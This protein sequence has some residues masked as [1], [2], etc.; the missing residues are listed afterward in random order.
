MDNVYLHQIKSL[1]AEQTGLRIL[2]DNMASFQRL[3]QNRMKVFKLASE[4]DYYQLLLRFNRIE[5][6]CEA[7][8]LSLGLTTGETYFFRDHGQIELLSQ[9]I[10]PELIERN[11][12]ERR[13]RIWSAGCSSGEEPYSLAML[14]D[15][16]DED[17]SNWQVLILGTDINPEAI[18]KARQGHYSD[19]SFRQVSE[20]YRQ[21]YFQLIKTNWALKSHIRQRVNFRQ[22]N[23]VTEPFPN[24]D[25]CQMD[26]ILCRNVFIYFEAGM[27]SQ[28]ANK[29]TAT[30]VEG[31]YLMT[32]HGELYTH[33]L[34]ELRT[35][36]F[37]NSIVYQKAKFPHRQPPLAI[38]P[39]QKPAQPLQSLSGKAKTVPPK[40][41]VARPKAVNPP[42]E[43]IAQSVTIQDAWIYANQGQLE[44]A[45]LCCDKLIVQNSLDHHPYYLFALLAQEQGEFE[46]AKALLKK[47]LY[48]APGFISAYLELGD[49]YTKENNPALARKMWSSVRNLLQQLPQDANIEMFGDSTAADILKFVEKRLNEQSGSC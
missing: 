39:S 7:E 25:I 24:A 44:Q 38:D 8:Q 34:G 18:V 29:I 43:R 27:V 4:A 10:L 21:H 19:W 45:R 14:L 37:P 28:I 42:S 11:R 30:L 36:V 9:H 48:L 40:T 6:A 1:I 31:G 26:L 16:L 49:I 22:L 2:D 15:E 17:L 12:A 35:R 46:E 33:Q 32:G 23:L 47:V 13:L 3:I 41:D 20:H 5:L